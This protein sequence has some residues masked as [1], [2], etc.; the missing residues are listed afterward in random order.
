MNTDL[1]THPFI[2][3]S[4][5][6]KKKKK[7]KKKEYYSFCPPFFS[8][9]QKKVRMSGLA[10]SVFFSSPSPSSMFL[11]RFCFHVSLCIGLVG[12]SL[13]YLE[14]LCWPALFFLLLLRSTRL[15]TATAVLGYGVSRQ[16]ESLTGWRALPSELVGRPHSHKLGKKGRRKWK[17]WDCSID[18]RRNRLETLCW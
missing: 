3:S 8:S 6:G 1:R 2:F 14:N 4:H 10:M 9:L 12:R 13:S 11:L 5:F 18:R 15:S 7:K 17:K 16:R